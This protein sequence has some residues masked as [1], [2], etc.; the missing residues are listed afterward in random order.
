MESK[1][2]KEPS[3]AIVQSNDSTLRMCGLAYTGIRDAP[4]VWSF[5]QEITSPPTLFPNAHTALAFIQRFGNEVEWHVE[6]FGL[7]D[8]K[9]ITTLTPYIADGFKKRDERNYTVKLRQLSPN[10]VLAFD[11]VAVSACDY[12]PRTGVVEYAFDSDPGDA[13]HFNSADACWLES[14]IRKTDN[15]LMEEA[16]EKGFE[17]TVEIVVPWDGI[18]RYSGPALG[19]EIDAEPESGKAEET[20]TGKPMN[21]EDL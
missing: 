10:S 21:P 11:P 18:H 4:W 8:K 16:A 7:V 14:H 19:V 6:D 20:P 1:N 17:L 12:Y 2:P 9:R 5:E 13:L 15:K 3:F